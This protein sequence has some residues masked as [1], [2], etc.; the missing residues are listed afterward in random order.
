MKSSDSIAFFNSNPDTSYLCFGK[1]AHIS[2]DQSI[3]FDELQQFITTHKG[4]FI[5]GYLTYDVKNSIEQLTSYNSDHLHFPVVYFHVPE[6]VVK[7]AGEKQTVIQ[8]VETEET[9]HFTASFFKQLRTEKTSSEVDSFHARISKEEYIEA[10]GQLKQHIQ[11][12]DIYEINFC[13]E[14]FA[15]QVKLTDPISV[16]STINNI[17]QAPFS[18][19]LQHDQYYAFCGSPER[20]LQKK[21]TTVLSQ[22]IKGTARRGATETEDERLKTELVNNPKER[23]ENVMIVDLVRNDLSKIAEKGTV[24]VDELFGVYTYQTVHQLVSTISCQ[25][26]ET[27]SFTDLIKATFPM[28]SMTGAPKISAMKLS[29]H[30]E[31]FKRGLYSGSI[32]YILPNGDFDFNVVIRSLLYNA[33]TNYLSCGVGGAIT[34]NSDA[35]KEYEECETKVRKLLTAVT[36]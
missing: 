19:Y 23:S 36:N 15:E 9:I 21:G 34:I 5:Y 30:Y 28:G 35:E 32:G 11:R 10:V 12:G 25:V 33:K 3:D 17:T 4:K 20:F 16:Y 24:K 7:T 22:P 14:Y 27:V 18:V 31:S 29:E 6:T 8:G 1:G 2:F 26:S 13:Q